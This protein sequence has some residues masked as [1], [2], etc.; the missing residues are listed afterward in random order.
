LSYLITFEGIEGCGKS[1]QAKLLA[2]RLESFGRPCLLTREPGG[3]RIGR[4]IRKV[5]LNPTNRQMVPEVEMALYF[6]DRAQHLREVIQPALDEGKYVICDRFTDSTLAYQGYARGIPRRL[7]RSL[8]RVM[9]GEYR[10]RFTVLLDIPVEDGLK[11]ARG[12]NQSS[13]K[14]RRE[15]RFEKERLVF[16]TRVRRAYLQ[17]A[18]KEPDRYV[19][20]AAEGNRRKI[21]EEVWK[22]LAPRMGI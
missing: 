1:T 20:V 17:M 18:R 8:D 15:A 4:E 16:H 7:I 6:A 11:R 22:R 3:T 12:R 21:H 19:V 2:K 13:K 9:T 14:G 10:P 5:L